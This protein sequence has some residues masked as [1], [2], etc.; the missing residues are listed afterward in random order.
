MSDLSVTPGEWVEVFDEDTSGMFR[1]YSMHAK[2]KRSSTPPTEGGV[3]VDV[4][5]STPSELFS[6]VSDG[7]L[8]LYVYNSG[9]SVGYVEIDL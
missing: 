7:V 2:I 4:D 9:R 5:E 3:T 1:I 6:N 8:K